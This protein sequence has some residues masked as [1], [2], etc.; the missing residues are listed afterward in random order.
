MYSFLDACREIRQPSTDLPILLS[1]APHADQ[2]HPFS[3]NFAVASGYL[4]CSNE[5][6]FG[7]EK[8][9]H[10][11]IAALRCSFA[12]LL[13]LA[14]MKSE[15]TKEFQYPIAKWAWGPANL[16]AQI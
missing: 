13:L 14:V 12:Q 5:T 7:N 3:C 16:R 1:V 9:K 2:N 15:A 8:Q 6:L 4:L 10:L 11:Q